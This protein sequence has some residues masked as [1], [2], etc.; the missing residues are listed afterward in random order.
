VILSP[1]A[2]DLWLDC[3]AVDAQTAAALIAP[4]REGML[5][6]HPVSDAVNKAANDTAAL[7]EPAAE[8]AEPA[9]VEAPA[10]KIAKPKKDDGQTSLF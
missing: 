4:A 3:R 2:F 5:E 9:A 10:R 8:I 7:I 1:Q 6:V